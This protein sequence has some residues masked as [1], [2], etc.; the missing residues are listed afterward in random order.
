MAIEFRKQE[1]WF[2]FED[3]QG[4][5]IERKILIRFDP[6]TKESS[7]LIFDPGLKIQH[8]DYTEVGEQTGGKN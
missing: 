2:S 5:G 1:E 4:N 7:R 6:L 3:N 8:P